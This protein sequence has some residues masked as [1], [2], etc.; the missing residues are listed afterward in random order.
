MK[1]QKG[2]TVGSVHNAAQ[3]LYRRTPQAVAVAKEVQMDLKDWEETI[4]QIVEEIKQEPPKCGKHKILNSWR[5]K[6]EKV[7]TSLLPFQIDEIVREV[8]KRISQ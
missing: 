1:L 5:I 8:H 3:E 7:P 4:N 6:L 2:E